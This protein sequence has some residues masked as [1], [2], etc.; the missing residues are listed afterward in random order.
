MTAYNTGTLVLRAAN[1]LGAALDK[2]A[3]DYPAPEQIYNFFSAKV[4][5]DPIAYLSAISYNEAGTGY[6]YCVR[7]LNDKSTVY[8]VGGQGSIAPLTF[9]QCGGKEHRQDLW[10]DRSD[11]PVVL[12]LPSGSSAKHVGSSKAQALCDQSSTDVL[13][14]S[15][16]RH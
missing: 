6:A 13:F 2:A 14:I 1:D 9:S 16:R 10:V 12:C 7:S 4:D 8:S 11:V 3:P 5:A 15:P